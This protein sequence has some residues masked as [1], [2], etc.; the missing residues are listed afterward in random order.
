MSINKIVLCWGE[1]QNLKACTTKDTKS[2]K[3]CFQ[4]K[5]L[6]FFLALVFPFVLFVS[7]V[8]NNNF[9]CP[10]HASGAPAIEELGQ[11]ENKPISKKGKCDN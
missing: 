8:V 11:L 2:T 4:N 9:D 6:W 3:N 10:L 5:P 1:K 7:F